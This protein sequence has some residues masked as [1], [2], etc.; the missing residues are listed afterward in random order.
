[1]LVLPASA[2]GNVI[3]MLSPLMISDA[4]LELALDVIDESC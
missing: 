2:H 1:M 3:R 4:D